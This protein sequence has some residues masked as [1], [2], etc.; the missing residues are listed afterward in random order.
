MWGGKR[1]LGSV[2][3][4]RPQARLAESTWACLLIKVRHGRESENWQEKE[5]PE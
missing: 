2:G 5:N 4:H 3:L 1:A